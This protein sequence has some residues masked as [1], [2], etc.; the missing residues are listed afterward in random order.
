MITF[1]GNEFHGQASFAT[2]FAEA[3]IECSASRETIRIPCAAR[4]T[5]SNVTP[6]YALE[7]MRRDIAEAQAAGAKSLRAIA[8]ALNGG[9]VPTARGGKW[10][11]ATLANVLKRIAAPGARTDLEPPGAV[12]R[13][14]T[15][16]ERLAAAGGLDPARSPPNTRF[17]C[18]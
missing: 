18:K 9:G 1:E 7:A 2:L 11:A 17:L 6:R 13:G 4:P 10:E 12:P 15:K 14:S 5:M 3:A 8:A 16:Q